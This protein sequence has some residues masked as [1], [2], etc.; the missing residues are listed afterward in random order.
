MVL[1]ED[2]AACDGPDTSGPG[3]TI[4]SISDVSSFSIMFCIRI[5]FNDNL[6]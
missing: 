5:H 4:S 1:L 2:V 3:T 6:D